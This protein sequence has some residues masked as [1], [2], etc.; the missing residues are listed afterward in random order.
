MHP[1]SNKITSH[2]TFELPWRDRLRVLFG[3]TVH[4]RVETETNVEVR[5]AS[6]KSGVTVDPIF[7]RSGKEEALTANMERNNRHVG[8]ILRGP[9]AALLLGLA[10]ALAPPAHAIGPNGVTGTITAANANLSSGTPTAA[11]Y[12]GVGLFN[13]PLGSTIFGTTAP[14]LGAVNF[15]VT[16]TFTATLRFQ[17]SMDEGVT[18][19]TLPVYP[20]TTAIGVTATPATTATAAGKWVALAGPYTSVRVTCSS[21]TSGTATVVLETNAAGFHPMMWLAD[22][23]NRLITGNS[24]RPTFGVTTTVTVPTAAQS[25]FAVEASATTRVRL[26]SLKICLTSGLQ[27]TAG[28]RHLI[29]AHTTA[30][31]TGGSALTPILYDKTND[32]AFGGI[33]RSGSIT[34]TPA[35]GSLAVANSLWSE[36]IFMP[37]AATTAVPCVTRNFDV[38]HARAPSVAVGVANGLALADLT[39]GSGGTGSYAIDAVFTEESN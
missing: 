36:V 20:V 9:V 15:Q 18:W 2:I 3:R 25:L 5:T 16:G 1:S 21:Y 24:D 11:S 22:G 32:S 37:A 8:G 35:V 30:A 13:G 34:T 31:S 28:E 23:S 7:R 19:I 6:A 10:L 17:G 26:R 29:L 4:V 12:V 14:V 27:T 39:G 33:A 38:G